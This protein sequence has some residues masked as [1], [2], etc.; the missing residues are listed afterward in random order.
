MNREEQGSRPSHYVRIDEDLCNGC[1][2]CMKVCPTRAIRVKDG[3]VARIEGPCI[4]CGECIRVCPRGAVKAIT[5][6]YDCSRVSP[7]TVISVSPVLYAQFGEDVLPNDVLLAL[8]RKF[9]YVYDQAYTNELCNAATELYIMENREKEDAVWPLISPICPVVNRLIGYRFPSLLQNILPIITAREIAARELKRRLHNEKV[10]R[11]EEVG[12]YHVTPCSAKM[13]AIGKHMFLEASHIDGA[14]GINEVYDI[15]KRNLYKGASD[16]TL[17]RSSG[18][19][20]GWG[21]SGGEIAGLETGNHL[22]VSGIQE[23]IRY[24]EKIEMGLLGDVEY[25]EFRACHEGCIGGPM[26]A[27]DSYQAK[28][29]LQR[30]VRMYGVEKRVRHSQAR[31]AY[32]EGWFFID[33]KSVPEEFQSPRKSIR[34]AIRRQEEVE[35]VHQLL[36]EKECGICGSPDCRTFA[37]DVVDGRNALENCVFYSKFK[38]K[39]ENRG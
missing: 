30:L 4:D 28:H 11:T 23:T 16:S 21:M 12:V 24:L 36:P 27:V 1:V 19:G 22:A 33:R 13:I 6:A 8:R 17:H 10:F 31:K 37:E 20:M 25:V 9:K 7:H 18:V 38:H 5:T 34:E 2:L 39:V 26:T 15:V 29:T 35:K 3:K 14:L 32:E